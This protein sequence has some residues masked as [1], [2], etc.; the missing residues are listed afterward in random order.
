MEKADKKKAVI[1]QPTFLPWLGYFD[2]ID[3]ADVFIF[4]DNVQFEKQSW[5]QRNRIRTPHGLEWVTVPVLIKGRFGQIIKDTELNKSV[6]AEKHLKHIRQNYS[7]ALYFKAYFDEFAEVFVK[8]Y[9]N[10][11]LGHF[12]MEIIKWL[13][14]KLLITANFVLSSELEASGKR[15]ELLVNILKALGIDLYISPPG[16]SVYLEKEYDLF[17]E[18]AISVFFQNYVHPEY[19]QVYKPFMPYASCLDLLFNEGEKSAQII[20]CGRRELVSV[21]KE[22]V[23]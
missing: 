16:S 19:S 9:K 21:D 13:C 6:F 15:S 10:L 12:N 8:A 18:R 2:L 3:Q 5:Q 17:Q 7:R 23:L 14:S 11:K 20:R 22:T 4:L 1:M